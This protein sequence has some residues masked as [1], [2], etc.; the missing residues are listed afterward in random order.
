MRPA[1][2][3][4]SST[5]S[6]PASRTARG[7]NHAPLPV[8]PTTITVSGLRRSCR[9]F[10]WTMFS[11]QSFSSTT[12]L[13]HVLSGKPSK[14]SRTTRQSRSHSHSTTCPA[15]SLTCRVRTGMSRS[16]TVNSSVHQPLPKSLS[17]CSTRTLVRPYEHF[18]GWAGHGCPMSCSRFAANSSHRAWN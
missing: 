10:F 13:L 4:G 7:S 14:A 2:R 6:L 5:N 8:A 11:A 18:S 9:N 1:H 16:S 3:Q 15:P 12:G 17:S